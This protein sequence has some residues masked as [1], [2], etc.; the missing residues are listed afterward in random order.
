MNTKETEILGT[1]DCANKRTETMSVLD[2][3]PVVLF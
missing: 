3:L 2:I 1:T